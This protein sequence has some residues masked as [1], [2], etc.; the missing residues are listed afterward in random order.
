MKLVV[1]VIALLAA[2]CS[3]SDPCTVDSDTIVFAHEAFK[4]Y[5]PVPEAITWMPDSVYLNARGERIVRGHV[6][7]TNALGRSYTDDYRVLVNCES[8]EPQAVYGHVDYGP[9]FGSLGD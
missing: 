8:G 4:P 9:E 2:S 1:A 6:T 5:F 3:T 7:F